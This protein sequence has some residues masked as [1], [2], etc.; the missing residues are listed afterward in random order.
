M[1][2]LRRGLGSHGGEWLSLWKMRGKGKGVGRVGLGG[3][4][5]RKRQVNAHAFV[6]TTLYLK[7]KNHLK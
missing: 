5:Q 1:V 4:R 2:S 7:E 3:E 6:K